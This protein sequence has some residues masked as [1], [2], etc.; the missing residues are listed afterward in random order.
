MSPRTIRTMTYVLQAL[1]AI[2]CL[3]AL[4]LFGRALHDGRYAIAIFDATLIVANGGLF[5]IQTIIRR[6]LSGL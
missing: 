4:V 6:K 3:F 5:Y 1:A 2:F